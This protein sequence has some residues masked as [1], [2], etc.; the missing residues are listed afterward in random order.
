MPLTPDQLLARL[1]ALGIAVQLHRH[2]P[3]FTVEDSKALRGTL[4]GGHCKNLFLKDKAGR[5]WLVVA[6]ED[7]AIDL[8]ALARHLGVGRLSFGRPELLL[9]VLGITPGAVSP[10]ALANDTANRVT[11]VLDRR[12]LAENLLN[13]HPLENTATAAIATADLRRFVASLGHA[14]VEID[15]AAVGA[16]AGAPD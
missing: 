14:P 15:L 2:P 12:M 7:T 16:A 11:P 10:F 4:P 9:E 13:F 5:L 1:A 6:L 3:L 8:K